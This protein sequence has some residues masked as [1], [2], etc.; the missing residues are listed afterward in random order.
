MIWLLLISL[1]LVCFAFVTLFGA[2]YLPTL[3]NQQ[4][5]ALELLDLKPGQSLIELG[6]GDG[7][8]LV[9]AA[10]QGIKST[11]YELNPIIFLISL[12]ITWRYRKLIKI[13]LANYW[14]AKWPKAEAIYVFSMQKFMEN[15]DKKIIQSKLTNVKVVSYAFTIPG[16]K[17]LS[18]KQGLYLYKY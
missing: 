13:K 15:L 5:I 18:Q 2:P 6:S 14:N 3:K 17:A 16:K 9:T 12:I 4:L 7:R 8:F 10:K 1:I 11:G